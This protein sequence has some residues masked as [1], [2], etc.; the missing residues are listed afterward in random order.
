MYCTREVEPGSWDRGVQVPKN[1]LLPRNVSESF[2]E[3]EYLE[4]WSVYSIIEEVIVMS[5]TIM[6]EKIN[7]REERSILARSLCW[8]SHTVQMTHLSNLNLADKMMDLV[9]ARSLLS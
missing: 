6:V 7:R 5:W 1:K 4:V 8:S 9:T 2:S 3:E